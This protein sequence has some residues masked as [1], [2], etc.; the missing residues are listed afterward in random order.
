ML[1]LEEL[2]VLVGMVNDY[3]KTLPDS[4]ANAVIAQAK[5]AVGNLEAF[6]KAASEATPKPETE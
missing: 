4:A 5:I 1:G 6:L 2:N 3:T